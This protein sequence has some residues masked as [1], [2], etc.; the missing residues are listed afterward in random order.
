[1]YEAE[2]VKTTIEHREPIIVGFFILKHAKLRMLKLNNNFFDQFCDVN[3]V[4]ELEMDTDSSIW[5]WQKKIR[6]NVSFPA[7]EQ[8][9]LKS[10]A[11]SVETISDESNIQMS[12]DDFR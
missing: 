7:S 1:M 8:N 12:R 5:L 2:L 9:G 10:E 6:M 3:K 4:E 11:R